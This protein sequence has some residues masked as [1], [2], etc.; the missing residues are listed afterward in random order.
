MN[1]ELIYR[2]MQDDKARIA[3]AR[4]ERALLP[5]CANGCGRDVVTLGEM[6]KV[7]WQTTQEED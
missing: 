3:T 4:A 5:V 6:C 2:R 1:D 7:C